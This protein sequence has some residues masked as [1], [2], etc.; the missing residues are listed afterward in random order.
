[1]V[2]TLLHLRVFKVC[3]LCVG[4]NIAVPEQD[5]TALKGAAW[6]ASHIICQAYKGT[7]LLQYLYRYV[8]LLIIRGVMLKR[9]EKKCLQVYIYICSIHTYLD[10]KPYGSVLFA[11]EEKTKQTVSVLLS[12]SSLLHAMPIYSCPTAPYALP[13]TRTIL[14]ITITRYCPATAST[15]SSF[16]TTRGFNLGPIILHAS[17]PTGEATGYDLYTCRNEASPGV[18]EVDS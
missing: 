6:L 8:L 7:F 15:I 12:I 17:M 9:E 14:L 1:M 4:L 5:L 2:Y 18:E 10:K 13:P 16:A 11:I 3:T